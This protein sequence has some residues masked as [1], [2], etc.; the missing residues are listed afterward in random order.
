MPFLERALQSLQLVLLRR[1]QCARTRPGPVAEHG[2]QRV[3]V[4]G[5]RAGHVRRL[6]AVRLVELALQAVEAVAVARQQVLELRPLQ[7]D[8][9]QTVGLGCE[10]LPL[11][12]QHSQFLRVALY[13]AHL[14]V[15][16]ALELL[17]LRVVRARQVRQLCLRIAQLLADRYHAA[18][19]GT[20]ALQLAQY[21]SAG[22]KKNKR[23]KT[24]ARAA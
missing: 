20:K 6:G 5:Q 15:G 8:L 21:L 16:V 2:P 23:R 18:V 13:G 24:K 9:R 14:G 7:F 11:R 3:G 4:S 10:L 12:A 17:A 22:E 19:G 1:A